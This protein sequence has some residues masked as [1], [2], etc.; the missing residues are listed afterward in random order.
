MYKMLKKNFI[1]LMAI[2]MVTVTFV[3][4]ASCDSSSDDDDEGGKSGL[5]KKSQMFVGSWYNTTKVGTYTWDFKASGK[6][7]YYYPSTT[8]AG[9]KTSLVKSGTWQYNSKSATLT[10]T[11]DNFNWYILNISKDSWTGS[12]LKNGSTTTWKRS[13]SK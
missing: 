8:A 2:I 1:S 4:F 3:G 6:C 11:V 13:G 7:E 12:S 5:D 10:T 9:K